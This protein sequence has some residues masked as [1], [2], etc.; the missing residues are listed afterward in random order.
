MGNIFPYGKFHRLFQGLSVT[1]IRNTRETRKEK[2]PL[3]VNQT[4]IT[5]EVKVTNIYTFTS[6]IPKPCRCWP[7]FFLKIKK[8]TFNSQH[9]VRVSVCAS[10]TSAFEVIYF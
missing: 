2:N 5:F 10:P 8:S 9:S 3:I 1:F 7:T 6:Y 4:G